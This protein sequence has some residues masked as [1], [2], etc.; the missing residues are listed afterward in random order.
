[1]NGLHSYKFLLVHLLDRADLLGFG[2]SLVDITSHSLKQF[3]HFHFI[4]MTI[5]E[6]NGADW[7]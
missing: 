5:N 3:G 1:M 4:M 6:I 7:D 2:C